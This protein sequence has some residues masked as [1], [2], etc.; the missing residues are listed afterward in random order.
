MKVK[1]HS[2]IIELISSDVIET[3]EELAERLR[4]LGYEVTQATVSRDIRE[5]RLTKIADEAGRL[6][7]AMHPSADQ[8]L[9]ERLIRIFRDG[10]LSMDY[11]QNII[12]I[13]TLEGMAMAVA[14]CLDSLG[15]AQIL[16]TIAGDN[17]LLCVAKTEE[18]AIS[19]INS[20]AKIIRK[21]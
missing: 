7:Y 10:V 21:R 3:Q 12:V 9:D 1:R 15:D 14:A 19:T 20:L 18:H 8:P 17:T 4:R 5:L 13:K 11:A 16:G 6:K 2:Q